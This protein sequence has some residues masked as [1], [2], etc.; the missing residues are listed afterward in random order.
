M[1]VCVGDDVQNIDLQ[2][3]Y[4]NSNLRIMPVESSLLKDVSITAQA[5]KRQDLFWL[6]IA[7][8]VTVTVILTSFFKKGKRRKR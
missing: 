7:G 6:I 1:G 2:C 4:E 5:G 3:N 8:L